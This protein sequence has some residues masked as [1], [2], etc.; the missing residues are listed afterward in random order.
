M[1]TLPDVVRAAARISVQVRPTPLWRIPGCDIFVKREDLQVSGSFKLRGV[2]SFFA[3][4]HPRCIVTASSGNHGKAVAMMAW[5]YGIP[6]V[7]FM[8]EDSDPDK[9]ASIKSLGAEV[10]AISG[11]VEERNLRAARFAAEKHVS[12]VS[13]SDDLLVVAGQ[14]SVGLEIAA[15]L[16][17]TRTVYVPVG[18]GGLLAGLCVAKP[19]WRRVPQ[20]VGVEPAAAPRYALSLAAG[21]PVSVP[22]PETIADG[23][24]GQCPGEMNFRLVQKSV[25]R[26]VTVSDDQI[27]QAMRMLTGYE[28]VVE[29]SGAAALAAA[30]ADHSTSPKVAII[31][32][33]NISADRLTAIAGHRATRRV[34]AH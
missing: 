24:R 22:A 16:P 28:I 17:D 5:Q 6:A 21:R 18:G 15:Q 7:V 20:I 31:S 34:S 9:I 27:V 29:P 11:G 32:G 8:T 30:L 2:A 19:A 13:S 25:D 33:G 14:G 3:E 23:L 1:L 4:N 10:V 26:L 12:I